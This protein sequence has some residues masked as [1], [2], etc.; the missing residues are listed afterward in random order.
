METAAAAVIVLVL[1]SP[2]LALPVYTVVRYWADW[3]EQRQQV[4]A[5][6]PR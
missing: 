5:G 3:A 4:S 6:M 1:F 2:F